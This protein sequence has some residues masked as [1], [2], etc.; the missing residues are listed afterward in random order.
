MTLISVLI[1]VSTA[2]VGPLTFYGFLIAAWT[3]ALVPSYKHRLF[4]PM[5]LVLGFFILTLAYFVMNHVFYAQGVVSIIIKMVG[6]LTFIMLI[7]K[8]GNL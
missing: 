7:L 2:L 1:A 5:S 6:G 4:F 3:Y 8:R